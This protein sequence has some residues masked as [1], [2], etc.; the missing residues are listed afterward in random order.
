[1][2]LS[3]M[4]FFLF[5]SDFHISLLEDSSYDDVPLSLMRLLHPMITVEKI[6]AFGFFSYLRLM[7]EDQ[8]ISIKSHEKGMYV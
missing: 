2:L 4:K 7:T 5:K 8:E 1:M 6:S 3:F